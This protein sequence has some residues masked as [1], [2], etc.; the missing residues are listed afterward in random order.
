MSQ[1]TNI[2]KKLQEAR[3][4]LQN[5]DI[6]KT[7]HNSYAN[8]KYFRLGD[9]I[10]AVNEILKEKGLTSHTNYGENQATLTIINVDNPEEQ[11]TFQTP[12]EKAKLSG[13]TQPIQ[14]LGA[15]Q[16][17]LRRYLWLTAMEISEEDPVEATTGKK[18]KKQSTKKIIEQKINSAEDEETLNKIEKWIESKDLKN[19]QEYLDMVIAK[20]GE[21][22]PDDDIPVI[23]ED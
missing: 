9:F 2:Y 3:V 1:E 14:E 7:G 17:Y 6:K 19:K 16:T 5:R 11:M 13:G 8:Y 10:G 20:R 23:E 12:Y 22:N 21:L 15:S 18:D 4:E